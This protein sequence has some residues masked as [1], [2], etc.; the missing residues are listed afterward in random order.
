MQDAFSESVQNELSDLENDDTIKLIIPEQEKKER[1]FI[2]DNRLILFI[3]ICILVVSFMFAI[4]T[5]S[6]IISN[7]RH[8]KKRIAKRKREAQ[9]KND[10]WE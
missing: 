8:K 5:I 10:I 6:Q 4:I 7:R 2:L 1:S 3:L 9:K